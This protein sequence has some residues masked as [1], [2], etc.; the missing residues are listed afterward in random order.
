MF[1]YVLDILKDIRE[2]QNKSGAKSELLNNVALSN[3]LSRIAAEQQQPTYVGHPKLERLETIVLAHFLD[4]TDT[5]TALENKV[6]QNGQ[7]SDTGTAAAGVGVGMEGEN[8]I[9]SR[10]M[11][12]CEFRDSVDEIVAVL[13]RHCPMLRTMS[14][15]GQQSSKSGG[16]GYTQ[17]EQLEVSINSV[18]CYLFVSF[19]L[20]SVFIVLSFTF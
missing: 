1:S 5:T 19:V 6:V 10:V 3:L 9:G 4:W 8:G 7:C 12:F 2:A 16:K 20:L 11:I 13:N 14:F 15:V 18:L 17:K